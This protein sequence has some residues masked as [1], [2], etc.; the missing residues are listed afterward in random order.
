MVVGPRLGSIALVAVM[1]VAVAVESRAAAE[2]L[3]ILRRTTV[4]EKPREPS[5]AVIVV[6]SGLSA[7]VLARKGDWVKVRVAGETGWV[8]RSW[9]ARREATN[10]EA[11]LEESAPEP[12]GQVVEDDDPLA[13]E[14]EADDEEDDGSDADV[15]VADG[16]D[17]ADRGPRGRVAATAAVGMRQMSATQRSDGAMEL[18]N[19]RTDTRAYAVAVAIDVAVARW[20]SI[21]VW[22][23][24]RYQGSMAS[25]GIR[26]S[27]SEEIDGTVPFTTHEVDGG[28]RAGY[29]VG[30]VLASGRVGYHVDLFTVARL[31][32]VAFMPSE[33]LTGTTIGAA[34]ELPFTGDG[35]SARASV[36]RL[37]SGKRG[38]TR[39][40]SDG[41]PERVDATWASLAIGYALSGQ[42]AAE[43]AYG[44]STATTRWSGQSA[45]QVDVTGAR[46]TD[47]SKQISIGLRHSF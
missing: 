4:L 44:Y 29:L 7:K 38:Q 11:P 46:R 17:A 2:T 25:P 5:A 16:A 6:E 10:E 14:D 40:L 30:P 35:L 21:V 31:D 13:A 41:A 22:L 24:A 36:D 12:S 19:Y 45:R 42:Y 39:G 8:R 3:T 47:V 37:V 43:L 32:N 1:A 28:L 34:L 27:L 18:A 23:G 20:D 26:Y 9:V 15:E 33:V